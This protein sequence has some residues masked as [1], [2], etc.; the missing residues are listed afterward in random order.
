MG[1]FDGIGSAVAGGALGL[2]GGVLQ[3]KVQADQSSVASA[4]SAEEA[5]KNREWQERMS[6]TSYQRA[7]KDMA[8]AGLNPMLAYQSGGAGTPS[9]ATGLAFQA[10]MSNVLGSAVEAANMSRSVSADVEKKSAET[11]QSGTQS[12]LNKAAEDKVKADTEVSKAQALNLDAQTA[13]KLQ[14][15]RTSSAVEARERVQ[16]AAIQDQRARDSATAPLYNI[17]E[18][19]TQYIKDKVKD[20]SSAAHGIR[21]GRHENPRNITI[22]GN[23]K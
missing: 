17:L 12:S 9:G 22:Y 5:A 7:V 21:F 4:V 11:E 6:N 23:S 3:N 8:A 19:G 14:E 2:L 10:Q 18:K 20:I 13:A 15:A 1:F 16:A